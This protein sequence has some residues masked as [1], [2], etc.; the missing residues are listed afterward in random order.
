MN[1]KIHYHSDCPYF[2]GCEN[3]LGNFWSSPEIRQQYTISFSYRASK[4]YNKGLQQRVNIDFSVYPLYFP[5]LSNP[6]ILP[7]KLPF[8]FK[9]IIMFFFRLLGSMPL[10]AYQIWILRRLFKQIKPDIVHINNGGYPAALSARAAVIAAKLAGIKKTVMVVN[11]MAIDYQR[12]SRWW[13]Y[14][15]DRV[16]AQNVTQFVTGSSAAS[17]QLQK[18]LRLPEKKRMFIHNGITI[19]SANETPAFVRK[20][21][22]LEAFDG[23]L[24]GVIACMEQRKGHRVLL[25]AVAQL[26]HKKST[27]PFKIL[28]EGDGTLR[29]ELEKFVVQKHLS[30]H[31]IF[32]GIESNVMNLMALIDVLILPSICNEDFPNVILEAMAFG[33][34]VI[35]SRLAGSSEQ[36]VN[37][38]TGI[39]VEPGHKEQLADAI[40]ALYLNPLLRNAM[41]QEGQ[42]RFQDHFIA[43]V[44]IKKYLSLYHT[45]LR[46]PS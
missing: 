26:I 23:V 11:N 29:S 35:A 1:P 14:P 44:A 30:D 3:M 38:K 27:P 41:G 40:E 8:F 10:L 7:N 24:F 42:K 21:F 20:R 4:L 43:P 18:V 13:E 28:I 22:N 12:F 37:H 15:I 5:E 45:L 2:A 46:S 17:M 16:V 19:R 39:L 34:P 32:T 33:K 36:I 31:C 25:E 9:R 6:S